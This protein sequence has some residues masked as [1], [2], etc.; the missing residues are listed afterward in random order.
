[1][2]QVGKEVGCAKSEVALSPGLSGGVGPVIDGVPE[3]DPLIFD[4]THGNW[5]P[6]EQLGGAT[7]EEI[8]E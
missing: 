1:M 2:A 7:E 8:V 6:V 3:V 4:L 5:W